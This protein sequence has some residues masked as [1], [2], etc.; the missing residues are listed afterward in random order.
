MI[1][2]VEVRRALGCVV[3]IATMVSSDA[4]GQGSVFGGAV[5]GGTLAVLEQPSGSVSS[6]SSATHVWTHSTGADAWIGTNV[7][8]GDDGRHVLSQFQGLKGA[9]RLFRTEDSNP[10]T[11]MWQASAPYLAMSAK[12]DAADRA[13]VLATFHFA[14]DSASAARVPQLTLYASNS[15]SP[16]WKYSFPFSVTMPANGVHVSADGETIVAWVFDYGTLTTALAVFGRATNVPRLFVNLETSGIPFAVRLSSSGSTLSIVSNIK[17]IILDVASGAVAFT[18]YHTQSVGLGHAISRDGSMFARALSSRTVALFQ[19]QEAMYLPWFS[20]TLDVD[21]SCS[22]IAFSEDGSTLALGYNYGYPYLQVRTVVLDIRTLPAQVV[23][24]HSVIGGGAWINTLADL[25]ISARGE[26]VAVG[27][28]GDQQGAAR[29]VQVYSKDATSGTWSTALEYDLPGSVNDVDVSSDGTRVA[30]A[31][32]AVHMTTGGSGGRI[33]TFKLTPIAPTMDL[34]WDGTPSPGNTVYFHHTGLTPG[35]PAQ[36]MVSPELAS[37]PL[38]FPGVG[39]LYIRRDR[40]TIEA[41]GNADSNGVFHCSVLVPVDTTKV[42]HTYYVQ[43]MGLEPP[44]LSNTWLAITI[45]P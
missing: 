45:Q 25:A 33:D 32:K 18:S 26:T 39:T 3:A 42:G 4:L 13:D 28:A 44:Q 27:L 29:E 35:R 14:Q 30:V 38:Y 6:T 37:P 5:H 9:T 21:A 7:A 43:S 10:P 23:F 11:P 8:I 17:T 24:D 41:V 34:T 2:W 36:L 20:Y 31:S 15:G 1:G 12:V 22:S 19:K 40:I 16:L